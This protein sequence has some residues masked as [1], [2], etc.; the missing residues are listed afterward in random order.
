[1]KK[2]FAVIVSACLAI[3]AGCGSDDGG[4][5]PTNQV[6]CDGVCIEAIAPNAAALHAGVIAKSCAFSTCHGSTSHKAGLDLS[7]V[8]KL[9][10]AVGKSST[11]ITTLKLIESGA[12]AKSYLLHKLKGEALAANTTQMP[13]SGS[14]CQAKIDAF[15]SWIKAGAGK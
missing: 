7:A 3:G 11:Q 4:G 13:P 9:M 6:D 12:P 8:D 15:E 14:V 10:E 1:M 2:R 5:C